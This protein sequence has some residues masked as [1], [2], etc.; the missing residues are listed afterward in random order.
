MSSK[1]SH[2]PGRSAHLVPIALLAALGVSSMGNSAL[3]APTA[4]LTRP[5]RATDGLDRPRQLIPV[6]TVVLGAPVRATYTVKRG[7]TLSGIA[8]RTGASVA[9]LRQAN[10]IGADSL[11]RV[12]DSLSIPAGAATAAPQPAPTGSASSGYRVHSGDTLGG[13]AR[14]YN[15]SVA[16]LQAANPGVRPNALQIGQKITIPRGSAAPV[17]NTSGDRSYPSATTQ[18]AN[19]NRSAL[20]ARAVPGRAQ[21][22]QLVANTARQ[23]GVDP[24]LAQAI[25]QQ[26]SGFDMHAVSAANAVGV[27]QITPSAGAWAS[28]LLGRR[29]D[30]LDPHDN[31]TAGVVVLRANLRAAGDE[32]TGIAAYYQGLPSVQ[33]KGQFA[34]TRRYVASV[35]TLQARFL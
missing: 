2:S 25:A 28:S 24:A 11:I 13:I 8:A 22:Q 29:L 33:S 27:M 30:L 23:H 12:G 16:A 3:A 26:E 31:V 20:A 34:D 21:M 14:R 17:A 35:Q 18:A 7:D 1:P 9:S 10:G 32:A 4:G 5:G 6:S 15:T 19:A